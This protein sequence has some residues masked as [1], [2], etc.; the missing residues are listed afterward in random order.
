MKNV[1]LLRVAALVCL[2]L[3]FCTTAVSAYQISFTVPESVKVGQTVVVQGESNIPSGFTTQLYLYREVP[4][5]QPKQIS[6]DEFTIQEGGDWQVVYDTT[7]WQKATYKIEIPKNSQYSYGSDS[8]T[9]KTFVVWDRSDEVEVTSPKTQSYDGTLDIAGKAV[10][11]TGG[12]GINVAVSGPSGVVFG[13]A[14]IPT[15]AEGLFSYEV[16]ISGPGTYTVAFSDEDDLI[17]TTEVTITENPAITATTVPGTAATLP[18][19]TES[20]LSVLSVL[21]G[22]AASAALVLKRRE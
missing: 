21:A 3:L 9:L 6:V 10:K 16:P 22:T 13:P 2:G 4:N 14:Y 17:T 18:P 19:A 20:P 5:F 7:G 8:V 12:A 1:Q 11:R 15:D